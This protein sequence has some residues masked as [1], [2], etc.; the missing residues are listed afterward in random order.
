M[1]RPS[2]SEEAGRRVICTVGPPTGVRTIRQGPCSRRSEQ[3][4]PQPPSIER[5]GGPS[6]GTG[7][8]LLSRLRPSDGSKSIPVPVYCKGEGTVSWRG[9]ENHQALEI[10]QN[11]SPA[12]EDPNDGQHGVGLDEDASPSPRAQ[13]IHNTRTRVAVCGIVRILDGDMAKEGLAGRL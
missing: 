1:S 12:P 6:T 7:G 8:R 5:V 3:D 9:V 13:P 2:G 11:L 4:R 10:L